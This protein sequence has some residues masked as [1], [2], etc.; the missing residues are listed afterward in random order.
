MRRTQCAT[1]NSNLTGALEGLR[2]AVKKKLEKKGDLIYEYGVE[3]FGSC[4]SRKKSALWEVK[5]RW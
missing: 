4:A 3:R 5:S 1:V 2:G